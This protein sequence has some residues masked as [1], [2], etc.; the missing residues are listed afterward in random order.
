[1]MNIYD[2]YSNPEELDYYHEADIKIVNFFWDKYKSNDKELK[3]REDAIANEQRKAVFYAHSV[4]N[5]KRFPKAEINIAKDP[6]SAYLYSKFIIK[7]PWEPGEKAIATD[8]AFSM[9]YASKIIGGQ[10]EPGEDTISKDPK[11]SF[12]YATTV[13][14]DKFPKGEK[15][16]LNSQYKNK[17]LNFLETKL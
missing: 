9:R 3:K 4:L 16:I 5:G 13:I 12:D 2:F 8:I 15:T 11:Y 10:W 17:Y 14:H 6:E 1:M 7:G